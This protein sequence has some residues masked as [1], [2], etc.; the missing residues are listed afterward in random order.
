MSRERF[1]AVVGDETYEILLALKKEPA[2]KK[3]PFVMMFDFVGLDAMTGN[4]LEKLGI[5]VWNSRWAKGYKSSAT[6]VD[7]SLFLGEPEDIHDESFGFLLPGRREWARW[8]NMQYTGY[9]LTFDPSEY[10]D[11]GRVRKSLGYGDEPLVLCS[12]GGTSVGKEFLNLCGRGGQ[13]VKEK[14]PNLHMVL[15]CGPRI[16]PA[17]LD[18]PGD[19]EVIGYLPR[20]YEHL[21]ACD[22]AVVQGGGTTTLELTALRRPFLYFP[23]EGHC[24]QQVQVAQRLERHGAGIRMGFTRT[25]PAILADAILSHINETPAWRPIRTDGAEIAGKLISELL[26]RTGQQP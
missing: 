15:N 22:L 24:E 19:I 5:Y 6:F 21:A 9:V 25:T 14:I 18:V 23:L 26:S 3:A 16:P 4:P 12:A 17:S 13:I 11:K 7:I 1:D 8:R 2:R 10:Q 20:L